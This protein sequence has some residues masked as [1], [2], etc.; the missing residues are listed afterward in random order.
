MYSNIV[1]L[2]YYSSKE[3]SVVDVTDKHCVL[4]K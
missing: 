4:S 3:F 2:V 1:L